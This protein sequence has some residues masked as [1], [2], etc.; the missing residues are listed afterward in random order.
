[1]EKKTLKRIF[2]FLEEKENRNVPFLW[3]HINGEPLTE[4]DLNI[5]GDL[6]LEALDIESLPNGLKVNGSAYFT[7][8]NI[9]S[10]PDGFEVSRS[11]FLDSTDIESLPE[12]LKVGR[13]LYLQGSYVTSLPKGLEVGENLY[14]RGLDLEKYSDEELREMIKPGFIKGKIFR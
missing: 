14:I 4:K 1:M 12:G 10:I 9:K 7:F 13:H 3:K 5:E 2:D 11:L 8:L 6:N